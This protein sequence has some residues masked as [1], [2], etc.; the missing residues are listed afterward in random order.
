MSTSNVNQQPAEQSQS[1]QK[2]VDA[3]RFASRA[4]AVLTSRYPSV[5]FTLGE[6]VRFR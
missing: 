2:L 5:D 3:D 6:F 4:S 1:S